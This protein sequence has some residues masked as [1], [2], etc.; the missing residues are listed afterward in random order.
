MTANLY[1]STNITVG[2]PKY[3]ICKQSGKY[4][5]QRGDT[6]NTALLD[7]D[8][9]IVYQCPKNINEL[10]ANGKRKNYSKKNREDNNA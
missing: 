6:W 10:L 2:Y 4:T 3:Y 5:L 7:K 9:N 1:G 8:G